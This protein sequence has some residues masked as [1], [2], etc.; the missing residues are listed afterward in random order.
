MKKFCTLIAWQVSFSSCFTLKKQ[1]EI[2]EECG[3]C[4]ERDTQEKALVLHQR[5]G[6]LMQIYMF[7]VK[8]KSFRNVQIIFRIPRLNQFFL[9]AKQPLIL[10]ELI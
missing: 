4:K 2:K 9:L 6:G 10:T 1:V 7:W 8:I 3:L 5:I